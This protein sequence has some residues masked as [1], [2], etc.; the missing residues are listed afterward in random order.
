[1]WSVWPETVD[2]YLGQGVAMLKAGAKTE[3]IVSRSPATLPLDRVLARLIDSAAASQVILKKSSRLRISL[4]G[5][6]CPALAVTIP[7][8]VTRWEERRQIAL[9][10]AARDMGTDLEQ[11]ACEIDAVAP[12]AAAAIALPMRQELERWATQLG[13]RLVSV[14]PLWATATQSKLSR[15]HGVQSL[16]VIEPDAATLVASDGKRG[17]KTM[18]LLGEQDVASLQA[19]SQH[20]LQSLGLEEKGLAKLGFGLSPQPLMAAAPRRWAGHWYSA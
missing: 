17:F 13:C 10:S 15:Q 9:A 3:T 4:S 2:V 8:G 7:E 1:V 14:A 6:W 20:W 18:S 12:G 5:A 19:H 16:L 11:I